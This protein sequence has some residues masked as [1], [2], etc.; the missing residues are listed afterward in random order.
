[1]KPPRPLGHRA[2]LG[3]AVVITVL[4]TVMVA[5]IIAGFSRHGS[6]PLALTAGGLI[7]VITV[8]GCYLFWRRGLRSDI[9]YMIAGYSVIAAGEVLATSSRAGEPQ[10]DVGFLLLLVGLAVTYWPDLRRLIGTPK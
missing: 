5:A 3:Y 10:F 1:M 4:M 7:V 2:R 8:I 6:V 9:P